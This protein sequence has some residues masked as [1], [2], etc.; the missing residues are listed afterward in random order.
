[1]RTRGKNSLHGH[2]LF[3]KSEYCEIKSLT[4]PRWISFATP[5]LYL[6]MVSERQNFEII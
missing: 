3:V 6:L 4:K 1:M 5:C 2:R